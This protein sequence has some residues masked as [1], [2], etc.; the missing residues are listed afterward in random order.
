MKKNFSYVF[1]LIL[2]LTS[3]LISAQDFTV[4]IGTTDPYGGFFKPVKAGGS[5][6][7]QI[8][9]KNNRQDT[10]TISIVKSNMGE[11]ESW[12][13]I[14]NN[15]QSLFPSQSKNFLL[16]V[17]VPSS[18][19]DR[20]YAMF[21][22]F[23]AFDKNNNNHSF[24]YNAQTII[25]DNSSPN[26]PSFT[27]SQTST[28]VFVN[29]W[30]SWDARSSAY[31]AWNLSSGIDGIKSYTIAIKNPDNTVKA[32]ISKNAT[33]YHYHTF[34]G[35]SPNTNYKAN[36]T[37]IDLAGNSNTSEMTATTAPAKPTGLTCSNTSYISTTL[38]WNASAGATEYNIY[39]FINNTN[40]LLNSVPVTTTSY[41]ISNLS[42]GSTHS[43]NVIAR[44][45]AGA[46]DRSDNVTVT[47]LNL[48][49][50]TGSASLCTGGSTYAVQNLFT[51]Y[52][53]NWT[54]S[55][56]ITK[57]SASGSNAV[58]KP[59]G[60]GNGTI[61]ASI[62][63]PTGE[64]LVLQSMGVWIGKPE[65]NSQTPLAYY[66][67]GI[68]N[69]VCNSQTYITNMT[70]SG[71]SNAT[72][73]RIAASPSNTSWYQTG[74]NV[75]FYFWS[76]NQTQVFRIS[77]SN[78]CGTTSYDFGFKSISCGPD[79]CNPVYTIAPNPASDQSTVIINIPAPCDQTLMQSSSFNGY[80]AIYDNQGTLKKKENYKT[81]GNIDLDLSGLKNGVHHIEIFDGKT[82]HKKTILIQK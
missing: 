4:K 1:V 17:A 33:D 3:G 5:F 39:E 21:L 53:V 70:I 13:T 66:S 62:I 58:F 54:C 23:N 30:D 26:A 49:P 25:V 44:G 18:A 76:V 71:A 47:T 27:V 61:Y 50:I 28:T 72:W 29:S 22:G 43:Y 38:T 32:S 60:Y 36:V 79:P 19:G 2:S 46:S 75:S 57:F 48:P 24:N 80:V 41:I 82:I 11:V 55:D 69:S 15:S 31:T 12:V 42:P 59:K 20:D 9:I 52:S 74:N 68:Y 63:A 67:S 64:V 14:D 56:N 45:I 8:E 73:Y 16:S 51:G 35:L 7:F 78:T 65:I 40:N 34:T 10:C 6:Q 37:A 77:S 81:Y